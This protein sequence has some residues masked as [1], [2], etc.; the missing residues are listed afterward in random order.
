[1]PYENAGAAKRAGREKASIQA[2]LWIYCRDKGHAAAGKG[3]C[4]KCTGLS[5]YAFKKIELCAYT[6]DKPVCVK[7]PVHCYEKSKREEIRAVMRYSGPRMPLSHP[8]LFLMHVI[9][10]AFAGKGVIKNGKNKAV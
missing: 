2:M 1:M 5:E 7:C 10:S 8:F 6:G 4:S 9:D 3:L